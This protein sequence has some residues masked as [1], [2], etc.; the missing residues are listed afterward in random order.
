MRFVRK[1]E[2]FIYFD[3]TR[4]GRIVFFFAYYNQILIC[5]RY[6]QNKETKRKPQNTNLI[7]EILGLSETKI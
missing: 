6:K 4:N 7:N 1:Q 2:N 3:K 5:V